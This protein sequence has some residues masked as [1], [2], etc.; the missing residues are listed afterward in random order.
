MDQCSQNP[1]LIVPLVESLL[2]G[3]QQLAEGVMNPSYYSNMSLLSGNVEYIKV[4][5]LPGEGEHRFTIHAF[6]LNFDECVDD[7]DDIGEE[8]VHTSQQ[9]LLPVRSLDGVWDSLIYEENLKEKLLRYVGTSLQ[10]SKSGVDSNII[11][12]NRVVLLHGPPGTGKTSLCKALA[13]K[14]SVRFA[15]QFSSIHLV[16]INAHSLFSKWFS[17]SGKLVMNLFA[18]IRLLLED[19]TSFVCILIGMV[20]VVIHLYFCSQE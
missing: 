17:E 14:I 8:V 12:W 18:R 13:Q 20:M 4:C 10:L 6:H 3:V 5:Q 15:S 1:S 9:W 16:E 11:A 2:L 19:K 7:V